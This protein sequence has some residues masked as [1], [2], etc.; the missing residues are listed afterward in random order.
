[1]A[2]G[3]VQ[4]IRQRG[5]ARWVARARRAGVMTTATALALTGTLV[6][7]GPAN[8]ADGGGDADTRRAVAA[9]SDWRTSFEAADAQ[10]LASTPFGE[11]VNVTGSTGFAPGSLL[12]HV[13]DVSASA[14]NGP[15]E[16]AV[17]LSDGNPASKWLAFEPTARITYLL[18]SPQT[19]ATWSLT[20]S[21]VRV[22]ASEA[23]MSMLSVP[24]STLIFS[25]EVR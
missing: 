2:S 5:G 4:V 6:A 22:A 14:E 17:N 1:M 20:T 9:G 16:V 18:D 7:A 11:P 19:A 23:A 12:G 25:A 15:G 3:R 8:A 13:T 24:V 21:A 10:P